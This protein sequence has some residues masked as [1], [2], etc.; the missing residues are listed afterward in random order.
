MA[1]EMERVA[2]QQEAGITY[3]PVNFRR[4][5]DLL[6]EELA[7]LTRESAEGETS[8]AMGVRLSKATATYRAE[9]GDGADPR[10]EVTLTDLGAVQGF[11]MMG[12]A[13]W[14][15]TDVDRETGTGYERTTDYRGHPAFET[16][17][18]EGTPRAEF[19]TI[20]SDRFLVE[21][22]GR[23]LEMDRLKRAM[24]DLDIAE[25]EAMKE[26]GRQESAPAS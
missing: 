5:R 12:L 25:L 3:E 6:P 4:L 26:A 15:M 1:D 18:M 22:D 13:A 23:D 2:E 8:G 20:V 14:R 17:D 7:G 10:L 11:A 24:E 21:L 19:Q 16:Y 9:A